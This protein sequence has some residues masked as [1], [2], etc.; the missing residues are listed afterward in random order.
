MTKFV[1]VD[2]NGLEPSVVDTGDTGKAFT[3]DADVTAAINK[4]LARGYEKVANVNAGEKDYPSTDAEK[5]I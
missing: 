2:G 1:D 3:K 5:V 4:I